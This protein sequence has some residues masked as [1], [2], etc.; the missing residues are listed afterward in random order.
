MAAEVILSESLSGR[1]TRLFDMEQKF[2]LLEIAA[3]VSHF[4][5]NEGLS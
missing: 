2:I 4:Q 5:R 1:I 3:N